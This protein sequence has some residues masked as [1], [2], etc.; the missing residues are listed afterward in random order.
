MMSWATDGTINSPIQSNE[1]QQPCTSNSSR[2]RKFV[3]DLPEN[4]L[5]TVCPP[6]SKARSEDP[7]QI[8]P[9]TM[10]NQK[11]IPLSKG[12]I[13]FSGNNSMHFSSSEHA[14][15]REPS[16]QLSY[17]ED[18]DDY[19]CLKEMKFSMNS[20]NNMSLFG[21]D[22]NNQAN[23]DYL[24][25]ELSRT[26]SPFDFGDDLMIPELS[27]DDVRAISQVVLTQN[28][29][30]EQKPNIADIGEFEVTQKSTSRLRKELVQP[31]SPVK[32]SKPPHSVAAQSSDGSNA[33]VKLDEVSYIDTKN[34]C[35]RIAIEM[36]DHKIAQKTFA[37]KILCRS[38]GTLSDLLNNPKPWD[39]LKTGKTTYLRMF[40]W[41]AQPLSRRMAI[42]EM[43][44]DDVHEALGMSAPVPARNASKRS[45]SMKSDPDT[46]RTRF[47]F[48]SIQK[49]TLEA[50]FKETERPSREMQE[51]I[52][53]HLKLDV[54]SVYNFYMNA[55]R[56]KLHKKKN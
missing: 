29:S 24:N 23:D 33:S 5:D 14:F 6:K 18:R 44:I 26:P 55:R 40:N 3:E 10:E 31:S 45:K 36:K 12:E 49:E 15:G 13:T 30:E 4:F 34:L 39:N 43:D 25:F 20:Q 2:K 22:S 7:Q 37:E 41:L 32:R 35:E 50:I 42:L 53:N 28:W 16:G 47:V 56:R 11:A 8:S 51:T 27:S 17:T 21:D 52:A 48:T 54:E 38:Q 1:S 46:K 9:M 19:Q